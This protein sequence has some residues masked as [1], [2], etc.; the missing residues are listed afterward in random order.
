MPP[1]DVPWTSSP[2]RGRRPLSAHG[3]RSHTS[4]GQG[5]TLRMPQCMGTVSPL[6]TD[7]R[8]LPQPPAL[9]E[10]AQQSPAPRRDPARGRGRTQ[11][12][13]TLPLVPDRP[14]HAHPPRRPRCPAR[15]ALD[16]HASPAREEGPQRNPRRRHQVHRGKLPAMPTGPQG[17]PSPRWKHA[18]AGGRL[19]LSNEAPADGAP[20]HAV[21]SDDTRRI[22]PTCPTQHPP[23]GT[24]SAE[25]KGRPSAPAPAGR[26]T[27]P[28]PNLLVQ[29]RRVTP[30]LGASRGPETPPSEQFGRKLAR[31]IAIGTTVWTPRLPL[32]LPTQRGSQTGR[33]AAA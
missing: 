31:C 18:C 8:L 6:P 25:Q 13:I 19:S 12:R 30:S 27:H 21:Y 32:L 16:C 23:W 33:H 20:L 24:G 22:P 28:R 29:A 7:A 2:G 26:D 5:R 4:T 3:A 15:D 11:W 1:R 17:A 14:L 9:P 10:A